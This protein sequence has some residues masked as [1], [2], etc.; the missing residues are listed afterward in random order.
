MVENMST[1]K[2]AIEWLIMGGSTL[3]ILKMTNEK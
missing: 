1:Y 3:F 2:L